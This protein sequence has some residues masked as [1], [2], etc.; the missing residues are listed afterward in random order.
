[1]KDIREED[2]TNKLF[3]N[4]KILSRENIIK[5]TNNCIQ[6][7]RI[8]PWLIRSSCRNGDESSCG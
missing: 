6:S 5:V 4:E 7:D 8:A 3:E 1:M 2:L